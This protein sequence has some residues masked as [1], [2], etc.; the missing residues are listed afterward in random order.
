M[1]KRRKNRSRAKTQAQKQRREAKR[2]A[3]LQAGAM[4]GRAAALPEQPW[5]EAPALLEQE[6]PQQP[7]SAAN[8][9]GSGGTY[10]LPGK[11][12]KNDRLERRALILGVPMDEKYLSVPLKRQVAIAADPNTPNRESTQ[13]YKAVLATAKHNAH[14]FEALEKADG[15][16]NTAAPGQA[17]M[18]VHVNFWLNLREVLRPVPAAYD[19]VCRL[20]EEQEVNGQVANGQQ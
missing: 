15:G 7:E 20:L 1:S 11:G 9:G 4:A 8:A 12:L 17:D 18:Q 5:V 2:Q 14:I 3:A 10:V 19:A 6:P 13:A 16:D